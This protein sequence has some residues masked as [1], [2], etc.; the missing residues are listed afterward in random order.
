M[1]TLIFIEHLWN[2]YGIV[3]AG[4]TVELYAERDDALE[5]LNTY[6]DSVS[7]PE[8]Q[9]HDVYQLRIRRNRME[10]MEKNYRQVY[11]SLK[12]LTTDEDEKKRLSAEYYIM[13]G[14]IMNALAK[15]DQRIDTLELPDAAG[16][17]QQQQ[18]EVPPV[19]QPLPANYPVT[20]GK[21]YGDELHWDNF[22]QKFELGMHNLKGIDDGI[23]MQFLVD[24][25][26]GRAAAAMAGFKLEAASYMPLWDALIKKYENKYTMLMK[27]FGKFFSLPIIDRKKATSKDLETMI[28][29]TNDLIRSV[30]GLGYPTE[31]WDLPV[32]FILQ[33]RLTPEDRNDW[34]T[35]RKGDESPKV[36][37]M[38]TFLDLQMTRAVNRESA[39]PDLRFKINNDRAH[40]ATSGPSQKPAEANGLFEHACGC[41]GSYDHQPFKC[42]EFIGASFSERLSI[43]RRQKMC[44][45]CLKRGHYT[46]ECSAKYRCSERKCIADDN[47]VLHDRLLCPNKV[48]SAVVATAGFDQRSSSRHQQDWGHGSGFNGR[49]MKRS[50][51]QS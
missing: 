2:F 44:F 27:R 26:Q 16:Q 29:Y 50:G 10:E 30:G 13:D 19:H 15:M 32:I 48:R 20:W 49:S 51:D 22:K 17:Q 40:P 21:F 38:L 5:E 8:F 12:R 37:H 45:I 14:K 23:K 25:L 11:S 24:A 42:G 33:A 47:K 41:C 18:P 9:H 36:G 39:L 7:A 28:N 43:A 34:E 4:T 31:N 35:H 46:N 1:D 3:M 6:I